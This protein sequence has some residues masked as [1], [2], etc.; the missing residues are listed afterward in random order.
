M[1]AAL[2]LLGIGSQPADANSNLTMTVVVVVRPPFAIYDETKEGNDAFSGFVVDLF[3]EV[4]FN[5][6]MPLLTP[7]HR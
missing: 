7:V 2:S 4:R 6:L 5:C 1:C 3:K